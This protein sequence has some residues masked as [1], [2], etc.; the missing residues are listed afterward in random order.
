[1][2]PGQEANGVNLGNHFNLVHNNGV[3]SGFIRI[4]L[5]M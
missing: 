5:M 4:A 1:M 2:V 3:S